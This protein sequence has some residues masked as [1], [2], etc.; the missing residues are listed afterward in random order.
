MQITEYQLANITT[1][2]FLT[3]NDINKLKGSNLI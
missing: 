2:P 3:L 1:R